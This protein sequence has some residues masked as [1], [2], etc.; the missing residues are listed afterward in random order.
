VKKTH[1]S[2]KCKTRNKT[3]TERQNKMNKI[4]GQYRQG[5]VLLTP[6]RIPETAKQIAP[7]GKRIVLATG[8]ATGH[9][10]TVDANAA[11]W[12]KD[13]DNEFVEVKT[14]TAL[15]HQEHGPIQ[16]EKSEKRRIRQ[17]EYTPEKVRPVV[18]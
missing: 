4:K 2:I 5:D 17:V 6:A 7:E 13:G 11:D 9:A 1:F 15:E 18:D 12:W 3:Q 16:L 8:E 10:H 14:S